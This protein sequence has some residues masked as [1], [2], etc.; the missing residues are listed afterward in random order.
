MKYYVSLDKLLT[1]KEY[2]EMPES[3]EKKWFGEV[4]WNE[5][6]LKEYEFFLEKTRT[7]R[8]NS[9][10]RTIDPKLVSKI[11]KMWTSSFKKKYNRS[12]LRKIDDENKNIYLKDI[13]P[14]EKW[15]YKSENKDILNKL[16]NEFERLNKED[17]PDNAEKIGRLL[18]L[19]DMFQNMNSKDLKIKRKEFIDLN[20]DIIQETSKEYYD[21]TVLKL[22][23]AQ[24]D[25]RSLLKKTWIPTDIIDDLLNDL[26]YNK[27]SLKQFNLKIK[28]LKTK[29]ENEKEN[30]NATDDSIAVIESIDL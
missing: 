4:D 30:K 6:E 8:A 3:R 16:H 26:K 19:K 22:L 23:H 29:L 20:K 9:S 21:D 7:S 14:E 18:S 15:G 12:K 11:S 25:I 13:K 28:D 17:N 2:L 24:V 1:E 10:T 27:I 5:E